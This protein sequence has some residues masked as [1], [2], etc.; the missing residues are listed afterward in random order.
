[1]PYTFG[2]ATT[3][4]VDL[5]GAIS[6][7]TAGQ[8][9]SILTWM[10]VMPTTLTAG[11]KLW[12]GGATTGVEIDTTTTQL[13]LK[14]D[15]ATTD[16]VWTTSDAGLAVDKWSFIATFVTVDGAAPGLGAEWRVWAGSVDTAP[17]ELTVTGVTGVAGNVSSVASAIIGNSS[18]SLSFQGDIAEYGHCLCGY[19]SSVAPHPPFYLA[20]AASVTDAEAGA[21]Y[22]RM[23]LP[24][25]EGKGFPEHLFPVE[26]EGLTAGG[27][28]THILLSQG[29]AAIRRATGSNANVRYTPT[30]SGAVVSQNG[31]P[32]PNASA[33]I[34]PYRRR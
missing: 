29:P 1:M 28:L 25:W 33:P 9:R 21:I 26:T 11:R 32:R 6:F 19:T 14:L 16:G 5:T 2:G 18:G 12:G 20:S 17:Q 3:N 24:L 4:S 27:E 34:T 7:I 30:I 15:H 8:D 10:W 13:R 31:H 22:R 23:V